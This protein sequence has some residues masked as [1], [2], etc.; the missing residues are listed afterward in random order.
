MQLGELKSDSESAD[1]LDSHA[2]VPETGKNSA[3]TMTGKQHIGYN[4]A[5]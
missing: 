3:T 5:L 4:P 1:E 2:S